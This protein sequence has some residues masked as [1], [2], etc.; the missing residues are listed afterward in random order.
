MSNT[1]TLHDPFRVPVDDDRFPPLSSLAPDDPPLPVKTWRGTVVILVLV[2]GFATALGFVMKRWA[3]LQ[4]FSPE[5]RLDGYH[6]FDGRLLPPEGVYRSN[7]VKLRVKTPGGETLV[8][9][10]LPNAVDR[11][12][13]LSYLRTDECVDGY[14]FQQGGFLREVRLT[15]GDRELVFDG[16][17]GWITRDQDLA[18]E[19]ADKATDEFEANEAAVG[20][21]AN[22]AASGNDEAPSV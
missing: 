21:D 9:P 1:R 2:L 12:T 16:D 15:V 11:Y 14:I 5:L 20:G 10:P 7:L 4:D 13:F 3:S 22:V 19:A 6:R 8:L 18:R 17:M